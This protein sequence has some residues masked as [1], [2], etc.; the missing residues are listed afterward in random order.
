MFI[1]PGL[2]KTNLVFFKASLILLL[3]LVIEFFVI[4]FLFKNF[5]NIAIIYC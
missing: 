4:Y 3:K 5:S 1:Q 2:E